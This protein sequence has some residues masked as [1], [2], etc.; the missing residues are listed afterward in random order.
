MNKV[1]RVVALSGIAMSV[2]GISVFSAPKKAS[3]PIT[4]GFSQVGAE[5]EWRTANTESIKKA[6]KDYG[7]TLKF[8]DA[9]NEQKNQIK[10][11]RSFIADKVDIIAFSPTTTSG[12]DELLQEAKDAKIPVILLDRGVEVKDNSLWVTLMGSD[13]KLEG[14][15]A[16]EWLVK[17]MKKIGKDKKVNIVELRGTEGS[18]P[19]VQRKIG[20]EEA[21]KKSPGFK[22]IKSESGDFT[23]SLGKDIMAEWLEEDAKNIDVLF[24]HNDDMA[25]GAIQAI[26]EAGLKPAKDIVI[27]SIDAVRGAFEA[28]IAGKLNCTVEC[29]PLLGP[30]LME[31]AIDLMDGKKV[32]KRVVT[33]EG[34]FPAEVAKKELPN[35]KY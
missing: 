4:I 30:Q 16:G 15:R 12:W 21:I 2:L 5:S 33:D 7:I 35:R 22:I 24:A 3:K 20:F 32:P 10:S 13:F 26:E 17:Y 34:V 1:L 19:A 9:M 18:D 25:I 29:S 8:E 31:A 27:I 6:A 28:M 23:R 14:V 11:I